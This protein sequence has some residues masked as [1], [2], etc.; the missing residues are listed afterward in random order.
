MA[1]VGALSSG[2]ELCF[3]PRFLRAGDRRA[4]DRTACAALSILTS[5]P[6]SGSLTFSQTVQ[7]GCL[8]PLLTR[9]PS[10]LTS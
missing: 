4:G 7:H 10:P 1:L 5:K 6:L 8:T 9:S 2:E 3:L